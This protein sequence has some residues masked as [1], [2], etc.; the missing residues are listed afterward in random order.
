MLFF[1]FQELVVGPGSDE[2]GSV[3]SVVTEGDGV[4]SESC[5]AGPLF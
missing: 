4:R 1:Q 3:A 2:D 5:V